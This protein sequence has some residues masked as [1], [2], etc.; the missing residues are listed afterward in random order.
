MNN[1][2]AYN[3]EIM[4]DFILEDN[5]RTNRSNAPPYRTALPCIIFQDTPLHKY[6]HSKLFFIIF[7]RYSLR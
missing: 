3:T 5:W 1:I 7:D 4:F 6:L 2:G